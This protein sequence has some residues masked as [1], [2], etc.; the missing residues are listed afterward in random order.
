MK[1]FKYKYPSTTLLSPF[2]LAAL[3]VG[4]GTTQPYRLYMVNK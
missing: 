4:I 2:G 3:G 1:E